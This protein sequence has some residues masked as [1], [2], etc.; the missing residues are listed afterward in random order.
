MRISLV[1]LTLNEIDGVQHVLPRLPFEDIDEVF[2][3]DGGST[4]GTR[5]YMENLGIRVLQQRSEGRGEAFRIAWSESSGDALIFFSP[6]GNEDPA[7]IPKFKPLLQEGNDMVIAS[8]M[9]K[10][11]FNEEDT[12]WWRPRKW[13]NNFFNICVNVFFRKNG[14]W[15][16]DS[17]NGFRAVTK[18]AF[19]QLQPDSIGFCIE[20]QMTI[21]CCKHRLSIAEFPTH[22]GNRIGGQTKAPSLSTGISFLRLLAYELFQ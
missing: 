9:M 8:R 14:P 4:D 1:I 12:H 20:Y 15:I 7:D 19:G 13:A 21:R 3:V 11:A 18:K 6:D 5:E 10:G 17:I 16:T 22:E 2:A